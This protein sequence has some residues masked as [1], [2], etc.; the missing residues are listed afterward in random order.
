MHGLN[1]SSIL[2]DE[3]NGKWWLIREIHKIKY[4]YRYWLKKKKKKNEK[5][6]ER[7][8]YPQ[9]SMAALLALRVF[10]FN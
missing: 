5:Q 6:L 4:Y 3:G 2:N 10:L 8:M 1:H 9:E 7:V